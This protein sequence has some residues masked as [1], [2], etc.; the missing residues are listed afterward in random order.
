LRR[1]VLESTEWG[2][3]ESGRGDSLEQLA[4]CP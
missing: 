2:C 3:T 1:K 4:S